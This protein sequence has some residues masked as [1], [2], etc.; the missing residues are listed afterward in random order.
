MQLPLHAVGFSFVAFVSPTLIK[1]AVITIII[2]II[3]III[4]TSLLIVHLFTAN[5]NGMFVLCRFR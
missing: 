1:H 4:P 5:I 3:I 2:I